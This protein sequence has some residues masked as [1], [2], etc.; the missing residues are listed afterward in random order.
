MALAW[1]LKQ[2][3]KVHKKVWIEPVAFIVDHKARD[4]SRE[5]AESVS[6]ELDRLGTL[7]CL[8]MS[9]HC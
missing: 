7:L 2:M 9:Y 1:L 6:S 5:E 3:P 8:L 4:G